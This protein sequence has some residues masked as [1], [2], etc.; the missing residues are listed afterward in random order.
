MIRADRSIRAG[1]GERGFALFATLMLTLVATL[2]GLAWFAVA[3]Y[4]VRQAEYRRDYAQA[5]WAAETGLDRTV[6]WLSGQIQPPTATR[7]L[8]QNEAVGDGYYDV[9]V[10]PDPDNATRAEKRFTLRAT[11]RAG[12]A[13]RVLEE[14]V[15]MEGFARYGY[16]TNEELSPG[17]QVIWFF[18]GDDIGGRTH[19]NGVFHIAGSPRFRGEVT[20]ASDHMVANPSTMVYGPSGWPAGSND[21]RFDRGFA[22]GVPEIQLPADTGDLRDAAVSGGLALNGAC[23]LEFGLAGPGTLSWRP[24]SGG[25]WVDVNLTTLGSGVVHVNGTV[26]VQGVVD[27]RL[28][29][30]ATGSIE[31]VG[32]LRYAAADPVTGQPAADCDDLLGLVAGE[33]VVIRD[34]PAARGDMIVDATVMAL[35]TSFTAENY[36]SGTPRGTLHLW[37]GL[38]QERRGPVG[39]F[40]GASLLTG[41]TKDYHYDDRVTIQPPPEFPYTGTYTR[42]S[43][44]ERAPLS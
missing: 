22:L 41:Y 44:S 25:A 37:G 2:M 21:P 1:A 17:G 26:R 10:I 16:F 15:R 14:V 32:D 6:T 38:I 20:S 11:G 39:T 27:G 18:S 42:V 4:E 29:L 31:L 33:N 43:W 35:G 8:F 7:Q 23:E 5:F 36:G 3:G 13:A 28:T 19:T 24:M 30:G 40:R 34:L 9:E 12:P